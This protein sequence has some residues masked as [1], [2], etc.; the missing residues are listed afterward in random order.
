MCLWCRQIRGEGGE[1][2]ACPAPDGD[3]HMYSVF[4]QPDG[5]WKSGDNARWWQHRDQEASDD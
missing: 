4:E 1:F 5:T 2:S 3:G